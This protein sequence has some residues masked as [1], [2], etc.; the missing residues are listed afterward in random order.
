MLSG[1]QLI[2]SWAVFFLT[3]VPPPGLWHVPPSFSAVL[4]SVFVKEGRRSGHFPLSSGGFPPPCRRLFSIHA[5]SFRVCGVHGPLAL[6]FSFF[7]VFVLSSRC[8]PGH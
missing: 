1:G 6:F 2:P 4:D 7:F 8:L 3:L 5:T